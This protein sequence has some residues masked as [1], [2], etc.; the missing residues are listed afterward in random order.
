[1]PGHDPRVCLFCFLQK[2][3]FQKI[4]EQSTLCCCFQAITIRPSFL[5]FLPLVGLKLHHDK[6]CLLGAVLNMSFALLVRSLVATTPRDDGLSRLQITCHPSTLKCGLAKCLLALPLCCQVTV[7]QRQWGRICQVFVLVIFVS[8]Q[9]V[10]MSD[11][12]DTDQ[13]CWC[14]KTK[15]G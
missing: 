5:V 3:I 15:L 8:L 6:W 10:K 13:T 2:E 1:M 12:A 9:Y 14:L 4:N 11:I 7:Q